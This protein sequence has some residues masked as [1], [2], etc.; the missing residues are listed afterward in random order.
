MRKKI[1][2]FDVEKFRSIGNFL[3]GKSE[4]TNTS[5][6]NLIAILVDCKPRPYSKFLK[7]GSLPMVE[8]EPATNEVSKIS[9]AINSKN[10]IF[11]QLEIKDCNINFKQISWT[12][13]IVALLLFTSGYL[14][15][16]KFF[17]NKE[18]MQW[19]EN[20]YEVVNCN[21]AKQGLVAVHDI[22][23]LEEREI[24]LKKIEVNKETI[25]FKNGKPLIWYGKIDGEVVYF[26]T[27]GTNP[28]TGKQLKPITEYIINKYILGVK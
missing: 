28:E 25:F 16:E 22:I 18:C 14:D 8:F 26:N 27:Y 12:I 4:K 9:N 2:N 17:P 24:N 3:K 13:G 11:E 7:S 6:L 20:H 1:E 21:T 23:P 5:S 19:N 10:Q 15:K